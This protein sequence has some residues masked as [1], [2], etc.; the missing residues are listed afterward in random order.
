MEA[1]KRVD[2]AR[3]AKAA[4]E[5]E[6]QRL[7]AIAAEQ[8]AAEAAERARLQVCIDL[9]NGFRFAHFLW[10]HFSSGLF[11]GFFLG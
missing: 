9:G 3:T 8:A 2:G 6:A 4:V 5:A 1:T 11:S 7:A 10:Q